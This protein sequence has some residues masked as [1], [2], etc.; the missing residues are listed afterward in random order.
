MQEIH[1]MLRNSQFMVEFKKEKGGRDRVT[2]NKDRLSRLRQVAHRLNRKGIHPTRLNY[3][4]K[5]ADS[6]ENSSASEDTVKDENNDAENKEEEGEVNEEGFKDIS[7]MR[8]S[9]MKRR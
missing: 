9:Q 8:Y 3:P 4:I 6:L 1:K 2:R 5:T 7:L